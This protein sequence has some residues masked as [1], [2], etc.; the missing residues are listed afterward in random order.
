MLLQLFFDHQCISISQIIDW[1]FNDNFVS[2]VTGKNVDKRWAGPFLNVYRCR[3]QSTGMF[4][5]MNL[6]EHGI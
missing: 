3:I 5:Y 4:L 2:E 6:P 1:Y